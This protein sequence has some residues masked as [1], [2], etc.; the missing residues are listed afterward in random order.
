M[1][2]TAIRLDATIDNALGAGVLDEEA[3]ASTRSRSR[4]TLDHDSWGASVFIVVGE[5]PLPLLRQK[6]GPGGQ[7]H[8]PRLQLGSSNGLIA[9]PSCQ[10][11]AVRM[12]R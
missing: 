6:A 7:V 3:S 2:L 9:V 12:G 4:G 10:T 11:A 1:P 5:H 8:Q